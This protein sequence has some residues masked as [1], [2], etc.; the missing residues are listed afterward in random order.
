MLEKIQNTLDKI[1]RS[2]GTYQITSPTTSQQS[3]PK[4]KRVIPKSSVK[5]SSYTI[6]KGDTLWDIAQATYGDWYKWK[7]IAQDNG[8]DE[9]SIYYPGDTLILR[10]VDNTQDQPVATTKP[11]VTTQPV[12]TTKSATNQTVSTAKRN[13]EQSQSYNNNVNFSNQND[14][15]GVYGNSNNKTSITR[16][17]DIVLDASR[18]ANRGN[19]KY[20]GYIDQNAIDK[21][22]VHLTQ[23]Q[24]YNWLYRGGYLDGYGWTAPNGKRYNGTDII[25]SAITDANVQ[26]Y[27]INNKVPLKTLLKQCYKMGFEKS[28]SGLLRAVYPTVNQK[29][30]NDQAIIISNN[31]RRVTGNAKFK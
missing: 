8:L 15:F 16:N 25:S 7:Q 21:S 11:V 3:T 14:V 6:K 18:P 2:Y 10:D 17:Y 9:N 28:I 31:L 20:I 22:G 19:F 1:R 4:R 27:L 23:D 24:V 29:H 5:G 30:I 13:N 12:T 26:R